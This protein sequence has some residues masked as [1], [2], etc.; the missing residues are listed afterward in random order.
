M[1][2]FLFPFHH[3]HSSGFFS[4][5]QNS[6]APPPPFPFLSSVRR[7][8]DFF[9]FYLSLSFSLFLQHLSHSSRVPPSLPFLSLSLFVSC[10]GQEEGGGIFIILC[11]EWTREGGIRRTFEFCMDAL[12]SLFSLLSKPFVNIISP[13][14]SDETFFP[15]SYRRIPPCVRPKKTTTLRAAAAAAAAAAFG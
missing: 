2:V 13:P 3:L 1:F 14:P 10:S 9:P 12:C 5:H 15:T 7:R 8:G 6:G 4:P 11:G